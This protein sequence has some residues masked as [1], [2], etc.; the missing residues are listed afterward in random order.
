MKS[1]FIAS[2][3]ALAS[4]SPIEKRQTP[5]IDTVILNYALALEHLENTF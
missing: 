4:A 3:I 5:D 1:A 2:I